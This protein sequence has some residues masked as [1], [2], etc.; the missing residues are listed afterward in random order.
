MKIRK[1]EPAKVTV[2]S[3]L[4]MPIHTKWVAK[5]L[6]D[7]CSGVLFYRVIFADVVNVH[8]EEHSILINYYII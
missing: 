8:I 5:E 2:S 1:D 3:L 6:F 4:A 7:I